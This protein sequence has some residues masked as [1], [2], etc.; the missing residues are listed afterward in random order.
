MTLFA[1]VSP[2]GSPGATT[3]ALAL[4]LAWP[5]PVVL[6]ECD[7][8]GGDILAGLF[9]GHLPGPPGLLGLALEAGRGGGRLRADLAAHLAPLDMGG[10][11]WFL[12]G[13]RD[14][15]QAP[16]LAPCWPAIATELAGHSADVIAD[17]GRLDAGEGQPASILALASVVVF[18]MRASVRQ[19]A[20]AGPRIEMVSAVAGGTGRLR[21]LLVGERGSGA[22]EVGRTSGIPVLG[23]LPADART[24]ALLSDGQGHRSGLHRSPLIRAAQVAGQAMI[25]LAAS[26]GAPG[27]A[28]VAPPDATWAANQVGVLPARSEP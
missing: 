25:E 2:G 7:P 23:S 24:A 10:N 4:A 6:A 8:A 28:G 13:I 11:G 1:L 9:A 17:C 27:R 15:R 18:V 14:P 3:S 5:R 22:R 19:V 12:A 26:T 16:G 20:A 21:L